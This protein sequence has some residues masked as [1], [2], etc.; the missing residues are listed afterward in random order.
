[1]PAFSRMRT[2]SST[3]RISRC[4]SGLRGCKS[5]LTPDREGDPLPETIAGVVRVGDTAVA[6]SASAGAVLSGTSGA[7]GAGVPASGGA[8][9]L[10]VL[11]AFA[12]I[13]GLILN[14]MP[15]VLPV[16]SIKAMGVVSATANGHEREARMHGL[17]YAAGVLVSFG[18][19]AAAVL[20]VRAATGIAIWGFWLQNPILVTALILIIF[21]IGLWLLGMFE[22]GTSVQS[23]S[24]RAS[25]QNRAAQARSLQAFWRRLSGHRVLVL[26]SAP[27]LEPS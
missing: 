22:L 8:T 9:S 18:A 4:V 3:R 17:W 24:A 25:P 13:G 2:K 15:C 5:S 27:R 6:I 12:L 7:G 23:V 26:S 10:P 16:L 19:L 1:M 11:M 20:S 21:L 14:L